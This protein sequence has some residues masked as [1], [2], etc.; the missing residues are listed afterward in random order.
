MTTCIV[1]PV[2]DS[3]KYHEATG[4]L[5]ADSIQEVYPIR[6]HFPNGDID[7][8]LSHGTFYWCDPR[9]SRDG[10]Q[11]AFE[12]DEVLSG[13]LGRTCETTLG[14]CTLP[15]DTQDLDEDWFKV[16]GPPP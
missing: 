15:T 8:D 7:P 9:P 3:E 10:T 11:V 1:V 14:E 12:V 6:S 5:Y 2:A 4:R 13:L 16:Q